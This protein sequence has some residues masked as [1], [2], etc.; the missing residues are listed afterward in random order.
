VKRAAGK[1]VAPALVCFAALLLG[2]CSPAPEEDA[3]PS[4]TE[5]A[6]K[7]SITEF[8]TA[9]SN[10]ASA[11]YIAPEERVAVFDNDGTL[12]AEQPVYFQLYF[13]IDRIK[14]MAADH[15]EWQEQEPFASILRDDLPAVFAQGEH[16]LFKMIDATHSG[17]THREFRATVKEW[18]ATARH[19][20]S[21]K[22][23]T[24][25]VYQPMLELLDYLRASGFKTYI[26]SGGCIE[27]MRVWVEDVYN[28][29]PEQVLGSS[30]NV[31]YEYRDGDA[32]LS[33]QPGMQFLNDKAGK[34]ININRTIGRRPVAAFGNSD[35]DH[36][37]LQWT[38]AGNG[39][40]FMLYVHHTDA[41]REW[42]Y[43]RES[44]IG[45]LDKGLD[46]AAEKGWTVVDM[47][48]DWKVIYPFE[49]EKT[50]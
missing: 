8:V 12:W 14:A 18:I 44:H 16:E 32:V 38:A 48:N 30:V 21:G 23:Y 34:P 25:M 19:P 4:W 36:Q 43:D 49:L 13:A 3:L 15:P 50:N 10:P 24:D 47:K 1:V 46:E 20:E 9:V 17:M 45:R 31:E 42:A 7:S 28:I 29:P 5:G 39:K 26:V 22:P 11:E 2:A 33:R 41:E 35:G 40:K 6:V 37:M 27:F